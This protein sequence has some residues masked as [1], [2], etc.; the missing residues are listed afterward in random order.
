MLLPRESWR[1][2]SMRIMAR[3]LAF[4]S[5]IAIT[6]EGVENLPSRGTACVYVANH[7][8]YLDAY[9]IVAALPREFSFMAKA[10]LRGSPLIRAF[11]HRIGT[12]FVS[13]DDKE[14]ALT[15]ARRAARIARSGRSLF[16]FPEGTFTRMPG[17]LPFRMGAFMAAME[18]NTPVIPIAIRGTRSILH[19]DS[20]LARRGNLNVIIGNPLRP[21][22]LRK[23]YQDPWQIALRLRDEARQ[24]ILRHSGEPDLG[25]EKTPL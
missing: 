2:R 13:R 21:D 22:K 16:F 12:E 9:V 25:H 1:W 6:L 3:L 5:G 11:L 20:L 14:Q 23:L 24:H 4:T 19:P 10:E 7:A 15:D 17:V 18:A 8:S